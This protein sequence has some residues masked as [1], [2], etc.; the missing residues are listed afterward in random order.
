MYESTVVGLFVFYVSAWLVCSVVW[1]VL[2]SSIAFC[3]VATTKARVNFAAIHFGKATVRCQT[4]KRHETVQTM[5]ARRCPPKLFV[6][7]GN[8]VF[9]LFLRITQAALLFVH[10]HRQVTSPSW[11]T[12]PTLPSGDAL[13][14]AEGLPNKPNELTLSVDSVSEPR[15]CEINPDRMT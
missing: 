15:K 9:P 13:P 7:G 4:R 10:V 8:C 2:A 3:V 6:R 1:I 12:T 14:C 5:H 11:P